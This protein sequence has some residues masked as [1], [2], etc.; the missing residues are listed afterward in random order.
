MTGVLGVINGFFKALANKLSI[1]KLACTIL[2]A[3]VLG[4][5]LEKRI[6]AILSHIN[7][8][9]DYTHFIFITSIII[10][11][12]TSYVFVVITSKLILWLYK[13]WIAYKIKNKKNQNNQRQEIESSRFCHSILCQMMSRKHE[14]DTIKL[15][16]GQPIDYEVNDIHK[17]EY[18]KFYNNTFY[19]FQALEQEL[20]ELFRAYQIA[21]LIEISPYGTNRPTQ[22]YKVVIHQILHEAIKEKLGI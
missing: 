1:F 8:P 4:I 17:S 16:Y 6:T 3:V 11:L 5:L 19:C 18:D 12:S 9:N 15:L 13:K 21:D 20:I 2:L 14:I 7:I 10:L 22:K